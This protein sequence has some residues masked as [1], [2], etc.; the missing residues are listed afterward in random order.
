M[1]IY[2]NHLGLR[3]INI[4]IHIIMNK[5]I[6][7]IPL[8][9]FISIKCVTAQYLFLLAGQ[10]NAVGQGDSLKSPICPP[11]LCFEFDAS[12]NRFVPLK[13]PAGKSWRLFQKA[14]TGSI[15][16]AFAEKLNELSGEKIYLVTAARGG[17]SCSKMAEM[18]NYGTWDTSGALFDL[19]VQK[20]KMAEN[21]SNAKLSGILWMQG[22]RDANAI[23]NGEL[24]A[25]EYRRALIGL[26]RRFRKSFTN[27][28]PFYIVQ[29]GYQQDKAPKGC[30]AVRLVQ[31]SV[32]RRMK[33][34]YLAYAETDKFGE[35]KWF[36]D[37]VHYNQE[38]LNDI[39]WKTASFV[40]NHSKH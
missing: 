17:A 9:L 29:T 38:A 16:P 27:N 13:D 12:E 8:Y 24:S 10:S 31:A 22:E 25:A 7:F 33:N 37:N 2:L 14:G 6:I 34:V 18:S 39:G 1:T 4:Y 28:L 30:R 23:L 32:A 21:M 19:A 5:R 35:R 36:K 26:I 11:N 3:S 20:T 15:A 40:F